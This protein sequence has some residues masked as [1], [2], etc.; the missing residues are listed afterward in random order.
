MKKDLTVGELKVRMG[1]S[2][3]GSFHGE[4]VVCMGN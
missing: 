4:V 2:G 1:N 3:Y